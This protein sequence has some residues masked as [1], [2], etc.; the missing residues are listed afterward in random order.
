[1]EHQLMN[2]NHIPTGKQLYVKVRSGF[3]AQDTTLTAWCR[4]NKV[5]RQSAVMCL[6][7]MWNGPKAK[8]LRKR[9]LEASGIENSAA[10]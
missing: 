1:M 6:S 3:V 10:A 9:L 8:T 7:G 2:S 5:P 4:E